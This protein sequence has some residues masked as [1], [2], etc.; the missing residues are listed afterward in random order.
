M[1]TA[2]LERFA[3]LAGVL[4]L[5]LA[6]AALLLAGD[7]PA[8][9]DAAPEVVAYWS[10]NEEK[11]LIASILGALAGVA[12][13][14]FGASLRDAIA[15]REGGTGRLATLTFAGTVIA[16]VGLMTNSALEFA[17]ADTAGDVT[18]EVTQ[19]LSALYAD[20]FFPMSGGFALLLLASGLAAL[21]TGFLPRWLGLLQLVVW[22]GLFTPIG[23]FVVLAAIAWVAA[24]SIMLFIRGEGGGGE[25]PA[26]APPPTAGA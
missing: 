10:D 24:V 20:F 7:P 9:D 13:V 23:F 5:V 3:P 8:A 15:R 1:R 11:E 6:V 25:A 26:A 2:G 19:A 4:F 12:L 17:A 22:I 16:G 21:R 14:W 18:A